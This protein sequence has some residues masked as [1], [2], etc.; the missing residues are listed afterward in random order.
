[1][2]ILLTKNSKRRGNRKKTDPPK[3]WIHKS[4]GNLS[5]KIQNLDNTEGEHFTK[6][7]NYPQEGSWSDR[8]KFKDL[9]VK[10]PRPAIMDQVIHRQLS[11][12]GTEQASDL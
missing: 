6:V 11:T 8:L 9:S 1:M 10:I 2:L 3:N 5:D 7:L 12:A 4:C